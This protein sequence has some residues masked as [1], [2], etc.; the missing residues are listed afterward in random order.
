MHTKVHQH[1]SQ[2]YVYEYLDWRKRESKMSVKERERG[3]GREGGRKEGGT[4]EG[5]DKKEEYSF[6]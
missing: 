4:R 3:V 6:L 5:R 2:H 1:S